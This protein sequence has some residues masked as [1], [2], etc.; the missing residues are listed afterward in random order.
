MWQAYFCTSRTVHVS[1][2]QTCQNLDRVGNLELSCV[3]KFRSI[4]GTHVGLVKCIGENAT[5]KLVR[6]IYL[7]KL[8]CDMCNEMVARTQ[9]HRIS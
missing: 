8:L 3:R 6:Q 2:H 1:G 9:S 5:T 4:H 7:N